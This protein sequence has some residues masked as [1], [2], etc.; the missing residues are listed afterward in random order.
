MKKEMAGSKRTEPRKW[1]D[2]ERR[3]VAACFGVY[4]RC[5]GGGG[6]LVGGGGESV[7]ARL[8]PPIR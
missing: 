4:D 3:Q 7:L 8:L 1:K 5:A 2:F 6:R